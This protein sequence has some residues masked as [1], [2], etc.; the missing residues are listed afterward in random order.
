MGVARMVGGLVMVA[1]GGVP[2]VLLDQ[3][4]SAVIT[5]ALSYLALGAS[6]ALVVATA[7]ATGGRLMSA[8]TL[9]MAGGASLLWGLWSAMATVR[10]LLS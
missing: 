3:V 9:I 8:L 6:I 5:A 7:R 10:L 4:D 1:V 2:A